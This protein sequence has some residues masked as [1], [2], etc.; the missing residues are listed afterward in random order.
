MRQI[1]PLAIALA[2]A[3]GAAHAQDAVPVP[4][5]GDTTWMLLSAF[6]S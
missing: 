6:W 4:D 2:V 1:F 3:A 5:K